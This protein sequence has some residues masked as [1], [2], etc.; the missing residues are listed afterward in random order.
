[1]S[2]C[3]ECV[4]LAPAESSDPYPNQPW[5]PCPTHEK[6]N[7][8]ATWVAKK[9]NAQFFGCVVFHFNGRWWCRIVATDCDTF[10]R[11]FSRQ[12]V[13]SWETQTISRPA[14]YLLW[15]LRF[16]TRPIEAIDCS[17]ECVARA[18]AEWNKIL[19]RGTHVFFV[20]FCERRIASRKF[21]PTG[22]IFFISILFRSRQKSANYFIFLNFQ[23]IYF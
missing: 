1:M 14:G 17:F 5:A 18:G 20:F 12:S 15:V 8:R 11:F 19:S 22:G 6:W 7:R 4:D 9:W 2:V 16:G 3:R 21:L 10:S 13:G 23:I